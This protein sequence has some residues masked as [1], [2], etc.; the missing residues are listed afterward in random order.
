MGEVSDI[1][2]KLDS[3]ISDLTEIIDTTTCGYC[4]M[5][6]GDAKQILTDYEGLMEKAEVMDRLS[7]QQKA[8][9]QETSTKAD[10]M[11]AQYTGGQSQTT[12]TGV[13]SR[14]NGRVQKMQ[15]RPVVKMLF[16][17][18]FDIFKS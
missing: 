11:I 16:G 5:I 6:I 8:F 7:S 3:A 9:L 12:A 17:D 13:G 1:K 15:N 14:V 2:K 10:E 4:K 18:V